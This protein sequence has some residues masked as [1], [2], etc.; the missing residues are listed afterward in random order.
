[1]TEQST[2]E[3]FRNLWGRDMTETEQKFFELRE[4]GYN[5]WFNWQEGRAESDAEHQAG[6][7]KRWAQNEAE[8]L[9]YTSEQG[10][11]REEAE[12]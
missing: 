11:I 3:R 5:G 1:M 9:R 7:E 8:G 10:W 6:V 2:E 12:R 4:S